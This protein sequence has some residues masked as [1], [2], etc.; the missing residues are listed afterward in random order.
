MDEGIEQ[1]VGQE[2]S[3]WRRVAGSFLKVCLFTVLVAQ[4]IF[5]Y[6]AKYVD[7][8][9]DDKAV[10]FYSAAYL[11]GP[12]EKKLAIRERISGWVEAEDLMARRQRMVSRLRPVWVESSPIFMAG[13]YVEPLTAVNGLD[14]ETMDNSQQSLVCPSK[15]GR[16][17]WRNGS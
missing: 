5:V 10:H 11:F 12:A 17:G 8:D 1:K 15:G 9:C 2:R 6:L 16:A 4:P 14:M 7:T 13:K 3:G